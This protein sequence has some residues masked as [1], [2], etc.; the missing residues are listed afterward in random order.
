MQGFMNLTN[1]IENEVTIGGRPALPNYLV[2]KGTEA[3]LQPR[4]SILD[5][6]SRDRSQ[7]V[8]ELESPFEDQTRGFVKVGKQD[9]ISVIHI[10]FEDR[11]SYV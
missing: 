10:R 8:P 6:E 7:D 11:F 9:A 3:V 2:P 1:F 4:K 5:V